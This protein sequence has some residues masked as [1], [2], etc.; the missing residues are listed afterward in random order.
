MAK[1][2]RRLPN[3][4]CVLGETDV[5]ITKTST[6]SSRYPPTKHGRVVR[7]HP[8]TYSSATKIP[9]VPCANSTC[10]ATLASPPATPHLPFSNAT[11][12]AVSGASILQTKEIPR[13]TST[14]QEHKMGRKNKQRHGTYTAVVLL[15]STSSSSHNMAFLPIIRHTKRK[16]A[17]FCSPARNNRP[18]TT[19]PRATTNVVR[20]H[21][22]QDRTQAKGNK[23][24]DEKRTLRIGL[25]TAV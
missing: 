25:H 9:V 18:P 6:L 24:S 3:Y 11:A 5:P 2:P 20:A 12:T 13:Q 10:S 4:G 22:R 16:L 7:T 23:T 8:Q 1:A 14:T 19:R 17:Q 15:K 21:T